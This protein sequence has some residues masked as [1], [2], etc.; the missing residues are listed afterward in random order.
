[1]WA[2]PDLG[3]A[4]D[5]DDRSFVLLR[6]TSLSE[7]GVD[8]EMTVV[9]HDTRNESLNIRGILNVYYFESIVRTPYQHIVPVLM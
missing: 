4:V 5:R 1:M 6:L 9:K 8:S 3:C 7:C 2:D